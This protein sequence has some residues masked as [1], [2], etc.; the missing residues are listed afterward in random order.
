M[1]KDNTPSS[2]A[3]VVGLPDDQDKQNILIIIKNYEKKHPGKVA[4]AISS[5][6]NDAKLEGGDLAKYGVANKASQNRLIFELPE[7]LVKKI[8]EAYPLMFRERPHFQ[9]FVKH[10]KALMIPE[11]Y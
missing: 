1:K 4:H 7:D 9:W 5:A 2:L 3:D 8:E 10:F 6:R 11:K